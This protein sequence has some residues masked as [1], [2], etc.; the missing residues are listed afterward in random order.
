MSVEKAL[1]EITLGNNGFRH[2]KKR[3]HQKQVFH[4]RRKDIVKTPRKFRT[5]G[6]FRKY[7]R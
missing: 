3:N 5:F 7:K 4:S 2:T 1:G 6:E